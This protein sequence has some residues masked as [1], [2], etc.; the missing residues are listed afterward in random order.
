MHARQATAVGLLTLLLASGLAAPA[1]AGIKQEDYAG[2]DQDVRIFLTILG[3][4]VEEATVL[5]DAATQGRGDE[6]T[7]AARELSKLTGGF[8]EE[9]VGRIRDRGTAPP[10]LEQLH[11]EII[12]FNAAAQNLARSDRALRANMSKAGPT[13]TS[14]AASEALGV[15]LRHLSEELGALDLL[16]AAAVPL[17]NRGVETSELLAAADRLE[18]ALHGLRAILEGRLA[19]LLLPAVLLVAVQAREVVLGDELVVTGLALQ[20][21]EPAVDTVVTILIAGEEKKARVDERG[22]Y[23][24]GVPVP[25]TA[26]PG[27]LQVRS[28]A[29]INETA[30][31]AGPVGVEVLPVPSKVELTLATTTPGLQESVAYRGQLST[32][33]FKAGGR[34][35]EI[36]HNGKVVT[37]AR[38]NEDGSYSGSVDLSSSG[39]GRDWVGARFRSDEVRIASSESPRIEV[40]LKVGHEPKHTQPF[41]EFLFATT[42][43]GL[44][45]DLLI[46]AMLIGIA[47]GAYHGFVKGD[48]AVT[49]RKWRAKVGFRRL[50]KF[51][52]ATEEDKRKADPRYA[53]PPDDE[54]DV[55]ELFHHF[56]EAVQKFDEVPDG[57][58]H[59]ELARHL[60][61]TGVEPYSTDEAAEVFESMRY[62]PGDRRAPDPPR[63]REKLHGVWLRFLDRKGASL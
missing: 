13:P 61:L 39:G 11:F 17:D 35:V 37:T 45:V 16:R 20:G 9:L 47:V 23:R 12:T 33:P 14:P 58:T 57:S 59:W 55:G 40:I 48:A 38:T 6:V 60:Q 29:F 63:L 24:L 18:T 43:L 21:G 50:T 22:R 19:R 26:T 8:S 15:A 2:A 27:P 5:L 3:E 31:T 28:K 46:G 62:W 56:L 44:V 36:L 34:T 7:A 30:V 41:A 52:I 54:L 10:F 1:S 32:G 49:I 25:L 53:F 4:N 42:G 51:K